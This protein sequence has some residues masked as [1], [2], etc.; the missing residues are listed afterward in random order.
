MADALSFPIGSGDPA[1]KPS[2]PDALAPHPLPVPSDLNPPLWEDLLI[3][4]TARAK[5]F[6]ASSSLNPLI[7]LASRGERK[8]LSQSCDSHAVLGRSG[9]A[10]RL[11]GAEGLA[12]ASPLSQRRPGK[13]AA[14]PDSGRGPRCQRRPRSPQN[15]HCPRLRGCPIPRAG[16]PW[17]P[18][19]HAPG[20][21]AP[22]AGGRGV[23][24]WRWQSSALPS[25]QTD[26]PQ[27]GSARPPR[28][29][30]ARGAPQ[31]RCDPGAT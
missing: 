4:E 17:A 14:S 10:V 9:G 1:P 20:Q 25:V 13:G 8:A 28:G 24:S 27:T 16:P 22:R 12:R 30:P 21:F 2:R 3:T 19:C 6:K 11:A 5:K 15:S 29:P 31:L 26:P 23:W 7:P 18:E